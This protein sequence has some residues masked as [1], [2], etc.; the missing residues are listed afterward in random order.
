MEIGGRAFHFV[1]SAFLR[2]ALVERLVRGCPLASLGGFLVRFGR[3]AS[4]RNVERG[5]WA[6]VGPKSAS[7]M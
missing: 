5:V 1:G 7:R 6:D 4:C 3:S 2:G